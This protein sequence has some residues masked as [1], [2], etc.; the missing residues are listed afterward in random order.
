MDTQWETLVALPSEI[1][2]DDE[3]WTP[4]LVRNCINPPTTAEFRLNG[5]S[6]TTSEGERGSKLDAKR[7]EDEMAQSLMADHL[8][9]MRFAAYSCCGAE[10]DAH[11]ETLVALPSQIITDDEKLALD[12]TT[13]PKS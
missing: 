12:S 3:T 11:S 7:E 13:S 1:I 9:R 2:P 4:P 5:E 8:E 10:M 6:I